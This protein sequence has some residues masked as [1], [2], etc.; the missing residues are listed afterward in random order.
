M[1]ILTDRF[2][3]LAFMLACLVT[4]GGSRADGD[5]RSSDASIWITRWDY[6]SEADVRRAIE[7]A[8]SLGAREVIWQVRG[9]AD[10][11][12]PSRLEPWGEE[13]TE[14]LPPWESAPPFDPL[15]VAIEAANERGL[16]LHAWINVFPLWRG[17]DPPADRAHPFN[18]RPEWRLSDRAGDAQ[19]L[20]DHYVIVNP[21]DPAV[22]SHI[23]AVCDDLATRYRIDGLHLDYVRFVSDSMK[24]AT[25][26]P[27]DDA[28]RARLA[29]AR[30]D[31]N[32][33]APEAM[34]AFVRDC[35]TETVEQIHA[36][37]Q[38]HDIELTA[39]VWR[40][41]DIARDEYLQDAADWLN[42]G[43][44]DRAMPMI[45]TA[46]ADRF[47]ADLRAWR[48]ACPGRPITPGLGIYRLDPDQVQERAR[49]ADGPH[50]V[51]LF[52]YASCFESVNPEEPKT[53]S[54]RRIRALRTQALRRWLAGGPE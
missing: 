15:A 45:Y 29:Q 13:L 33:D 12:Y 43:V 22:R 54:E 44:L 46:D 51:A 30:P 11:F 5:A 34:R 20:N 49:L 32:A 4:A 25:V 19:P 36:V 47:I 16:R 39:A 23:V 52:G 1:R 42:R 14:F 21:T 26:Y 10:A 40:N 28:S 6:R 38:T 3:V 24:D 31:A 50:G 9:Q 17:T 35:I 41:P 53:P 27:G 2:L 8:A 37:C 18:A 7:D 48:A